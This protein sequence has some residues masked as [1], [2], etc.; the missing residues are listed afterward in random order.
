MNDEVRSG[1]QPDDDIHITNVPQS[2]R[3]FA[4]E[5]HKRSQKPRT[6]PLTIP[7]KLLPAEFNMAMV[8]FY[9][10]E[11]QRFERLARAARRDDEL[12]RDHG[13]CDALVRF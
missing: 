3:A 2:F 5:V 7:Q 12:G 6:T 4:E 8:H 9:R 13:R 11:V 1:T 10:G